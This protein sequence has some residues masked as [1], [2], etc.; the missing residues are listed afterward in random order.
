MKCIAS[1]LFSKILSVGIP[2]SSLIFRLLL[3]HYS[4]YCDWKVVD[5]SSESSFC[6]L[7][8]LFLVNLRND[9]FDKIRN[10][11]SCSCYL[12]ILVTKLNFIQT[13]TSSYFWYAILDSDV[14]NNLV[15]VFLC[16][17]PE[18]SASSNWIVRVSVRP[19]VC[20]L[21]RPTYKQSAQSKVW[22]MIK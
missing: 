21:F 11:K 2:S 20:P 13:A 8:S 17:G 3:F 15:N 12:L 9:C 4:N 10:A 6:W 16:P 19:F 7:F 5:V 1:R 22:L 18:R 14:V